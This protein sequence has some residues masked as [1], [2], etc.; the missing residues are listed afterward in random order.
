MHHL[1]GI[2]PFYHR[3]LD[4]DDTGGPKES[5][6]TL[7]PSALLGN[8]EEKKDAVMVA[9][10]LAL[11]WDQHEGQGFQSVSDL[12]EP[13]RCKDLWWNSVLGEFRF[14]RLSPDTHAFLHG[15]ATSV[16]G[17]WYDGVATCGNSRCQN[18]P[19]EWN[20]MVSSW[21]TKQKMECNVC[22][23]EREKRR[24]VLQEA[25]IDGLNSKWAFAP[26]A[27]PNNDVRYEL[28]KLQ[29]RRFAQ[30]T[31]CATVV[32]SRQGQGRSGGFAV[33]P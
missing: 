12:A 29:A 11:L 32:N 16:P 3:P 1:A 8:T 14:L 9:R 25:E 6:Q 28:N 17:S 10:G 27:V 20:T 19:A 30:K 15:S 5:T 26:R 2:N 22:Q 24:R 31:Q 13:F 7:L 18:L 21:P 23:N 33:G 4:E